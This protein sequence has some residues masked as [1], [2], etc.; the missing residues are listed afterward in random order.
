MLPTKE[1]KDMSSSANPRTKQ[2]QKPVILS[3]QESFGKQDFSGSSENLKK[4]DILLY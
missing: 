1:P 3:L 4:L 2:K